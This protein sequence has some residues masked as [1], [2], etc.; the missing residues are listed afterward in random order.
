VLLGASTK[1]RLL[2]ATPPLTD[3]NFNRSVVYILDHGDHGAI[4]LVLNRPSDDTMLSDL[5]DW[6]SRISP[7]AVLFDGGPVDTDTL[8]GLA[9]ARNPADDGFAP[10]DDPAMPA[11][12]GTVDLERHP[13]QVADR[14]DALRIFR[15]YAGWGGGQLEAEI[16]MGGWIVLD[17]TFDDIFATNP[18][19]LWRSILARQPGRLAWLAT[20]PDDLEWN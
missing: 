13:S 4:G 14:F 8:I 6:S 18:D 7:P 11:G 5:D 15:G 16:D 2:L 17:A 3:D 9:C 20:C 19:G 12:L 10:L 1:G